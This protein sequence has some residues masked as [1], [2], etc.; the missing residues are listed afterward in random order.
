ME[1]VRVAVV[2][3]HGDSAVWDVAA[4]HRDGELGQGDRLP[5]AAQYADVLGEVVRRD[6]IDELVGRAHADTV[7]DE[8]G[9]GRRTIA[10]SAQPRRGAGRGRGHAGAKRRG[11]CGLEVAVRQPW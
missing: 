4:A 3:R 5:V 1:V 10:A 6:G 9:R 2:K 11:A 8:D 7:V